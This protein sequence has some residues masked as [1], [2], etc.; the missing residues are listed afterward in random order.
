MKTG[1]LYISAPLVKKPSLQNTARWPELA[2]SRRG[3]GKKQG[4]F[5]QKHKIIFVLVVLKSNMYFIN[6]FFRDG[7]KGR[8]GV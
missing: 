1:I 3:G 5:L 8:R 4:E 2:V 7:L 6:F